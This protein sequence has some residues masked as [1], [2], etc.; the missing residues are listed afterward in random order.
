MSRPPT[1]AEAGQ[2]LCPMAMSSAGAEDILCA[3]AECQAWTK[4]LAGL[5]T[6]GMMAD[7]GL[8]DEVQLLRRQVNNLMKRRR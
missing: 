1:P 3:R 8:R 4:T 6:C 7:A 5:W 2:K